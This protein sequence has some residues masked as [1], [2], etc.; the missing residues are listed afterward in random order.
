VRPGLHAPS[1]GAHR[2]VFWD[3]HALDLDREDDAG[4]RQQRVLAPDERG[5]VAKDGIEQHDA[6]RREREQAIA[7][8]ATP[9]LVVRTVTESKH[10]GAPAPR[11]MIETTSAERRARP[12]GKRFGILVHAILATVPLD[13]D[14]TAIADAAR[15]QARI[16]DAP[17]EEQAAARDAA[18]AALMHPLLV[19][20][21]AAAR[22]ERETAVM[23]VADDGAIVE[24]VVDLA[25]FEEGRGWT[26]VDFKTDVEIAAR[27]AEYARQVDAYAEAIAAATGERATG[28]LLSI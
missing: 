22:V 18:A 7:T 25:F 23:I 26:V 2:V 21:R 15:V 17:D 6:W 24:G 16:V 1:A 19:R 14:A 9:S 13:A 4:Q 8:A 27:E 12:H 11:V 28:A 5:L 20:A 10:G 3:P